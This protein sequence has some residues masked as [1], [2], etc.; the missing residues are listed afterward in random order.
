[1]GNQSKRHDNGSFTKIKKNH[2]EHVVSYMKNLSRAKIQ[3]ATKFDQKILLLSC[4]KEKILSKHLQLSSS[5][6]VSFDN[7][8]ITHKHSL[9]FYKF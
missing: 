7:N 5:Y 1:M 3:L 8:N 2:G 9:A 6:L 4:R